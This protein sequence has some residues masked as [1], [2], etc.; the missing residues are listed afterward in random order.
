MINDGG[1]M[2]LFWI[3]LFVMKEIYPDKNSQYSGC[4]VVESGH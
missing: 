1:M 3:L 2:W 4:Y